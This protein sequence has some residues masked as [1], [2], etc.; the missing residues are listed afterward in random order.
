MK[1]ISKT[2]QKSIS[3]SK[4]V[5]L[6]LLV[7]FSVS[8]ST[9][10]GEDGAMGPAGP[11]GADG[12][13]NVI[14]KTVIPD[15]EPYLSWTA[16]SYFGSAANVHSITDTD[17][18]QDVIDNSMIAVYFQ[19]FG[20]DVWYPMY[21]NIGGEIITFTS[22]LNNLTI[23]AYF[24]SGGGVLSPDISKVKYFIIDNSNNRTQPIDYTKMSYEE[25]IEHFDLKD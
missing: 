24:E 8:C 17:I 5:L 15:P 14:V 4:Y 3:K 9:E 22:S 10:D 12:N 7:A 11:A 21:F 2:F 18:S 1:T 20:T 16:G 25:L 6:A 19:L 23:Y 13:A